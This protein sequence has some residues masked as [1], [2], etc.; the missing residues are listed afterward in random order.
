MSIRRWMSFR[1]TPINSPP[2]TWREAS[3]RL[4]VPLYA[5]I[6]EAL[7][8]GGKRL[9]VDAV[10][11]IG[12]HGDYP[13]N[14]LGQH[15]YPRKEFFDQIVEVMQRSGRFVP[16]FNDKHLSYRWDWAKEMYDRSRRARHTAHGRQ[17][18][19]TGRRKPPLEIAAGERIVEAVSIHGG[20][21]ESYDFHA[22]EV[23][24]SLIESRKG[25]ETGVARVQ[26]LTGDAYRD[27]LRGGRWSQELAAAAMEAERSADMPR[28]VRSAPP[29][30]PSSK[31]APR[32]AK[33][34]HA[35][36]V[37]YKDGT[38]GTVLKFGGT[39]NRWNFACRLADR[40]EAV[41]TAFY[42]GPWGEP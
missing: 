19:A 16:L 35:L 32:E 41:A 37:T 42:N 1:S 36:I 20:G 21:L 29:L 5:S 4:T 24:Q 8:L 12:E 26:L 9:A 14:E 7:C 10:L 2:A 15:M 22:L 34:E 30:V 6:A 3:R 39:S 27:A 40:Q 25:G 33:G 18:R 17:Q 28:Q 38:H 13:T 31:D 11:L 23:M